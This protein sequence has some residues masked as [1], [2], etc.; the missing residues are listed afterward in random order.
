MRSYVELPEP[1][2]KGLEKLKKDYYLIIGRPTMA[3]GAGLKGYKDVTTKKERKLA[4]CIGV[5]DHPGMLKDFKDDKFQ[6]IEFPV[7]DTFMLDVSGMKTKDDY[8]KVLTKAGKKNYT[9]KF[10]KFEKEPNLVYELVDWVGT[11]E[12]IDRIWPLYE[13]T[14]EKNGFTVLTKEDFYRYHRIV[15]NQKVAY[16]WDISDPNNK[17]LTSF[18]TAFIWKDILHPMWCGTD[19]SN[20]LNRTCSTYFIILYNMAHYAIEQQNLNWVDLG[21]T[22]RKAKT[23]IGYKPHPCSLYFRCYNTAYKKIVEYS[24]EKYYDPSKC[25][26]DP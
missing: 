19:Y 7:G 8:K 17:K 20:P 1:L 4:P 13:A 22:Q 21:A 24:M 6:W 14:G 16:I 3:P 26:T 25:M 23:S 5:F 2:I 15:P 11:D 18:N 9:A 12:N 10:K